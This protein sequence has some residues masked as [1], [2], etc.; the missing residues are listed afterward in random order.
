MSENIRFHRSLKFKISKFITI[1]FVFIIV[2]LISCS[3]KHIKELINAKEK[4]LNQV[5]IDTIDRRFEV[6]YQIL[7]VGSSQLIANPG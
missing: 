3:N 5:A 6:S 7:E 1:L 2:F 4:G